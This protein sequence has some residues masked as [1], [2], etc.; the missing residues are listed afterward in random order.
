MPQTPRYTDHLSA[1]H[2]VGKGVKRLALL[3]SR[4]IERVLDDDPFGN[5]DSFVEL[6]KS[7]SF[8]EKAA[9]LEHEPG[10]DYRSV[11]GKFKPAELPESDD[12]VFGVGD[13]EGETPEERIRQRNID[14][15]RATRSK[16]KDIKLW[17][18][19]V[20]FQDEVSMAT[21]A[22]RGNASHTRLMS[23]VERASAC[24][25]KLSILT[26]ALAAEGNGDSEELLLAY[27]NSAAQLWDSDKLMK[28]WKK[29]LKANPTLTGLWIE[30]VRW[31]QTNFDTFDVEECVRVYAD[32]LRL[33]SRGAADAAVASK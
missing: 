24:D 3:P 6:G 27:M 2:L 20:D 29:T 15:D 13:D 14:Y 25:V 22:F 7:R 21:S 1:R 33:L 28:T 8:E 32:C 9:E 17:L 23:Q 16:P 19:F 30:F 5:A 26:R 11:A 4:G 10:Q 12:E 31:R 18:T